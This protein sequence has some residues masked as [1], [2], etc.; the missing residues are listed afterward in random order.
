MSNKTLDKSKHGESVLRKIWQSKKPLREQFRICIKHL[1]SVQWADPQVNLRKRLENFGD[2]FDDQILQKQVHHRYL[3]GSSIRLWAPVNMWNYHA[4]MWNSTFQIM[5]KINREWKFLNS[6]FKEKLHHRCLTVLNTRLT[7]A[8]SVRN[9]QIEY[10][11][12]C[13]QRLIC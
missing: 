13:S 7:D 3:I 10:L 9:S 1:Q 6:I 8:L 11:L 2:Q 4:E 5:P 12:L